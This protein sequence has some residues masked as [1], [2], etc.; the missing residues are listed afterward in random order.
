MIRRGRKPTPTKLRLILGGHRPTRH[1][2]GDQGV[3]PTGPRFNPP[4][5][6]ASLKGVAA[7][8][9]QRYIAPATWLDITREP[10]AI[11]FC[12]LWAEF[13]ERPAVFPA[14]KHSQMR[15]YMGELG[16]TDERNRPPSGADTNN[17]F[18]AD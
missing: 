14:A 18:F 5:K 7:K 6:P 8:A 12:E 1:D 13:I 3:S 17:E 2:V 16:L 10:A 11:A 9:W 4:R 15:A